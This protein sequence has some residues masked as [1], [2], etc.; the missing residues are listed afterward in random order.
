MWQFISTAFFLWCL[1]SVGHW[2]FVGR[3]QKRAL[4]K[5]QREQ[6]RKEAEKARILAE[7]RAQRDRE[8]KALG[9]KS[10]VPGIRCS[11][12]PFDKVL[13][14]EGETVMRLVFAP[15]LPDLKVRASFSRSAENGRKVEQGAR[16]ED[17]WVSHVDYGQVVI[18]AP[19][20]GVWVPALTDETEL[21]PG[22]VILELD[23]SSGA[24]KL[25]AEAE[26]A[27][28]AERLRKAEE[29]E[30][31]EVAAKLKE[32]QRRR[33]LEEQVRME[34]IDSGE[35]FG[36]QPKR[37]P[38]PRE[39]V[40]AVYRRDGARC[41]YCGSTENLQLDHIIP[42]SKGGATSLENLQLLCQKCNLEK[43][44]KIG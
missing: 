7:S 12:M 31:A 13:R 2:L 24:L 30:K 16:L 23:T 9:M 5:L 18:I 3:K 25:W 27:E 10:W 35:L 6:E 41:V 4:K 38:I 11:K 40:D 21:A 34:M 39:V 22:D 29:R 36:E 17:V 8:L 14:W 32:R 28:R 42:F 15:V 20:S 37:P 33:Q 26:A 19:S 43:S 44:N 1:Y